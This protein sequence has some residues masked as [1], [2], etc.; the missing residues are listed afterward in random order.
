M[1]THTHTHCLLHWFVHT[2]LCPLDLVGWILACLV[3]TFTFPGCPHLPLDY[4]Y[5]FTHPLPLDLHTYPSPVATLHPTHAFGWVGLRWLDLVPYSYLALDCTHSSC[6]GSLYPTL[7]SSQVAFGWFGYLHTHYYTTYMQFCRF[8]TRLVPFAVYLVLGL[9]TFGPHIPAFTH[10]FPTLWFPVPTVT[11]THTHI[12]VARLYGWLHTHTHPGPFTFGL[13]G[14]PR[15]PGYIPTLWFTR[16]IPRTPSAP[17][18]HT[19]APYTH[20][21]PLGSHSLHYIHVGLPLWL[22]LVGWVGFGWLYRTLDLV[23]FGW[24]A[25]YAFTPWIT[26]PLVVDYLALGF[27]C[28]IGWICYTHTPFTPQPWT[29]PHW[30]WLRWIAGRCPVWIAPV[31]VGLTWIWICWWADCRFCCPLDLLPLR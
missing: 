14:F 1:V 17:H 28:R 6:L 25:G 15:C 30:I 27:A 4:T 11:H 26:L 19:V 24:I 20:V 5:T 22:D 18:P 3:P 13:L 8:P 10:A 23:T 9:Y 7:C 12:W 29:F 2:H 21:Y 31:A 16:I